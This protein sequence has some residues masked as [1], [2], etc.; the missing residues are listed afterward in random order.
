MARKV[1]SD[2]Y[3]G[4][5]PATRTLVFNQGIQK[6]KFVLITNANT[7]Q[8]IFN[9]SDPNL[10]ITSHAITTNTLSGV[11][12]T[13]IVLQYDTTSM[14]SANK[15]QVLIDEYDEKFT[16]SET[17]LDPVNKFRTS[18]PQALIDTDFEYGTQSTKWESISLVNNRSY[19]YIN[20]SANTIIS[21]GGPINVTSIL[22]NS[23]T[24]YITAFTANTPLLN[25]PIFV[26]DTFVGSS[27]RYI[28]G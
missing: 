24:G 21:T 26:V 16:P 22:A 1:I 6:E 11:I 13:T 28:Y 3:Y 5:T 20:S 4:F 8:V 10:K 14:S 7:N 17:Y 9:F 23:N 25:T 2:T 18:S 27:R 19:S 15:L 12:N